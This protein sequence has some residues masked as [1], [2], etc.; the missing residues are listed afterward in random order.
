MNLPNVLKFPEVCTRE[1]AMAL[2]VIALL[3]YLVYFSFLFHVWLWQII[4]SRRTCICFILSLL[5]WPSKNCSV[6]AAQ[7]VCA[8]TEV[9]LGRWQQDRAEGQTH[10]TTAARESLLQF[11]PASPSR[12]GSFSSPQPCCQPGWSTALWPSWP[13]GEP[14]QTPISDCHQTDDS[15]KTLCEPQVLC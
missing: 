5:L 9:A 14:Q 7:A 13:Q 1:L 12:V 2:C 4:S 15:R 8:G 10:G 3:G 11:P 6:P